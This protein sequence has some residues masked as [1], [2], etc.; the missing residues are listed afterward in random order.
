MIDSV[1]WITEGVPMPDID[2][3]QIHDWLR[4][5][6][7]LHNRRLGTLTY[8][9]C[10]DSK[11]LEVNRKFLNHDYF[12]DIITFDYSRGKLVSG[13]L[14]I[15][16]DTVATN[17]VLVNATYASELHR[18]IVHGLLHLCGINDKGPGEREIMEQHENE[19]LKLIKF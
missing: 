10:N 17:A 1:E 7:E 12:T 16:L 9:F 6:A 2:I 5:V 18:V 11:I 14:Y 3:Q 8:I 13:D 19:A 4:N 15:S